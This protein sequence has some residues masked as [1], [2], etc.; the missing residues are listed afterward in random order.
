MSVELIRSG[1]G[2]EGWVT[3]ADI[4]A[5][6]G[7]PDQE[8]VVVLLV[9]SHCVRQLHRR[10]DARTIHANVLVIIV[11]A[12]VAFSQL[13]VQ[14]DDGRTLHAWDGVLV[15]TVLGSNVP[16]APRAMR[17]INLILCVR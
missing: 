7:E 9:A 1:H 6:E 5:N 14:G 16:G 13:G 10:G 17:L 11:V 2:F 12:T 15:R 4:I 3:I 8:R